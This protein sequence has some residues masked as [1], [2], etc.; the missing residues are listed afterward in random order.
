MGVIADIMARDSQASAG[1]WEIIRDSLADL[2]RIMLLR[3][4][5]EVNH[6]Q[7]YNHVRGL[8]GQV[9][10]CAFPN[11]FNTIAPAEWTFPRPY[12][13]EQYS[14]CMFA[15]AYLMG[16]HMYFLVKSIWGCSQIDLATASSLS[17]NTR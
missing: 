16:L 3:C 4:Y 11:L 13:L 17:W 10:L 1:Y 9:W 2:V 6:K 15:A 8:R 5:D 7:L 12:F 14:P